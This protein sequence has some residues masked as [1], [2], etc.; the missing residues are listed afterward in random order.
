[1]SEI[2][3]EQILPLAGPHLAEINSRQRAAFTEKCKKEL[4][5]GE[6]F[7]S[8]LEKRLGRPLDAE[9]R[10]IGAFPWGT[11]HLDPVYEQDEEDEDE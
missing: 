10:K 5:S 4:W 2:Q 9:A 6:A 7:L 1:M 11:D 3:V 8:G